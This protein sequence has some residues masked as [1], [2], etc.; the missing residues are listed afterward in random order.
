MSNL[1]SNRQAASDFFRL[2]WNEKNESA[3]D[4]F[5]AENAAGNDPEFGV[6]AAHSLN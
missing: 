5:I 3:I 2:I 1:E 6:P 4:R